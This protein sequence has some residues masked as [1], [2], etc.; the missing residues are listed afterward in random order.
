[1]TPF[2]WMYNTEHVLFGSKGGLRLQQMG[3]K[4]SF[5][6]PVKRHSE[7]PQIFFDIVSKA[8]PGPRL[9]M[10]A[11]EPHEGFEPWGS[12]VADRQALIG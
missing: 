5:E 7:K 12:N 3:M 4:L 9:E 6:A 2:S 10:F 11:R 1:M 8:S